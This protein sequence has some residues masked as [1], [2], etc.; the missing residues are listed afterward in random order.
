MTEHRTSQTAI[1]TTQPIE[2]TDNTTTQLPKLAHKGMSLRALT[3]GT[4]LV[5]LLVLLPKKANYGGNYLTTT[6]K[7]CSDETSNR[8]S[9]SACKTHV[10]VSDFAA[11]DGTAIFLLRR[12]RLA[13][14]TPLALG[15][16]VTSSAHFKLNRGC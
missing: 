8:S 5:L 14:A 9:V 7:V 16:G 2:G 4:V 12:E 3:T 15:R 10:R 1:E 6:V 13:A 11:A